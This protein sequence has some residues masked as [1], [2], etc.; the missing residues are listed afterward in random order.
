[1]AAHQTPLSLG[2][3][4][5]EHW[6]GLPFPSRAL[7]W[8]VKGKSLSRARL[9]ATPWTAAYQAPLSMGFSMQEY[10]SGALYQSNQRVTED[11]MVGWPHWFNAHKP[12]QIPGDGEGQGTL[13]CLSPWGRRVGHDLASEQQKKSDLISSKVSTANTWIHLK[14]LGCVA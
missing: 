4:R 2:F 5:Q 9:I 6:S 14:V 1:M 13:V 7:K 11:E 8:K 10:W 12:G 3:S